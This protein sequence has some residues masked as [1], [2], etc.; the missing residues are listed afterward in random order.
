MP[1]PVVRTIET[2]THGRYLL[3]IP[4]QPTPV[5]LLIGFHGYGENADRH[6]EQLLQLPGIGRWIAA[7]VQG[8]HRFYTRTDDVVASWMTRQDRA[9]A[10]TDNIAYIDRVV[11]EIGRDQPARVLLYAGF[12]Q[13]VATAFR[14]AVRGDARC[15]GVIALGG[16]IPPELKDG[17]RWPIARVLMGRGT[18]DTWYTE[19]KLQA[20]LAFLA[21]IAIDPQVCRFPGGHEWSDDFR[22]AAGRF[23]EGSTN[24]SVTIAIPS[25]LRV[26]CGGVAEVSM[27]AASVRH[28]LRQLDARHRDFIR[29]VCDDTGEVRRHINI[30][31]NAANIRDRSGLD[32]PLERGDVVTILPAVSGG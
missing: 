16:D 28:A 15:D 5:G 17:T 24:A 8:L 14:A 22:Q 23:L 29:N 9:L 1:S 18:E 11:A 27:E 2:R 7:S 20:D 30:F 3:Q 6:L 12:S 31:I 32:T 10:I 19:E 26:Y 4:E 25:A 13:G 21:S